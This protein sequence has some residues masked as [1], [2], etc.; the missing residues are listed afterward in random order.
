MARFGKNLNKTIHVK[1]TCMHLHNKKTT[2][3]QV[4]HVHTRTSGLFLL[5]RSKRDTKLRTNSAHLW[6]A[7]KRIMLNKT[8]STFGKQNE[9]QCNAE[10]IVSTNIYFLVQ[11]IGLLG[12]IFH[13]LFVLVVKASQTTGDSI[14][15]ISNS[16]CNITTLL[17]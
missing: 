11:Q 7:E 3:F 17:Q 4:C 14:N 1:K 5:W 6:G 9:T 13:A 15:T 16:I 8:L 12:S 10:A 2:L